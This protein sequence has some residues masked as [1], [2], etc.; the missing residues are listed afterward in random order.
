MANIF[1]IWWS[2]L[3]WTHVLKEF[4]LNWDS[5]TSLTRSGTSLLWETT[6]KWNRSDEILLKKIFNDNDFDLVIDMIPFRLYDAK[7][8]Y[9][10]LQDRDIPL[11]ACSSIDVYKAYGILW[12][13]ENFTSYEKCPLTE[14]SDLRSNL[15]STGENYNKLEIETL[16]LSLPWNISIIRLPAIYWYPD[17]TRIEKYLLPMLE[18]EQ[19]IVIDLNMMDWKFSRALNKNCAYWIFLA[20]K[21]IWKQVYNLAEENVYTEKQWIEKIWKYIWWSWKIREDSVPWIWEMNWKHIEQHLVWKQDWYVD[22]SKIRNEL[23]FY[24]KYDPDEW[25]YDCILEYV[26]KRNNI[27]YNK[28]Y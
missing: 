13:T 27:N 23:W 20:R 3:V 5:I 7:I 2:G 8:L 14:K 11:I 15:W 10:I 28:N 17:F 22:T 6:I 1:I 24:E 9:D 19:E 21:S 16:Y 18:S 26:R 12:S 4:I 25:L